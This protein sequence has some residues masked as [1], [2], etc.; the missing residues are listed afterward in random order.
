MP[1]LELPPNPSRTTN[2]TANRSVEPAA[3][4]PG[5]SPGGLPIPIKVR[6][7]RYGELEEHEVIHLLTALDEES[8]RAR[9]RESVYI[10]T[11]FFF[12]LAWFLFYGP[13]VLFH[14]PELVDPIAL[15]KQ[16]DKEQVTFLN[17]PNVPA[18]KPPP[19]P[20]LDRK[21]MQQ[22]QRQ[23]A[24][25]APTP[26]PSAPPPPPQ[27]EARNTAP[28]VPQPQMPL[29]SAPTPKPALA[30]SPLPAAPK[31]N[32]AQNSNGPGDAI[33][34]A[35]RNAM[36]ARAEYGPAPGSS[37]PLQ[38]GTEILSDTMGVDFGPYMRRLH[39]DIQRNWEP[40]IP[41]EVAPPL[42]KRG[43]ARIRF[44][45][46]PDG[47]IGNMFLETPSGDVALDRAAWN[48]ITSEGQFPP[49]PKEFHGPLL[50]LRDTF[51][52]NIPYPQ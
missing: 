40:L 3:P 37:S 45:I 19:H 30:D 28:P 14:Q 1:I 18:P 9:F 47:Q 27:E 7:G 11:L 22:I 24:L 51:L 5:N 12:A 46:L 52:Y 39:N 6:T 32:L 4:A 25:A 31:P 26:Q 16:H 21:T 23:A 17:P 2:E 20:V 10:S 33:Q 41:E 43:I 42:S 29:P 8:A 15:M 48:A 44:T 36:G 50:E 13:R 49:L 35:A 34:R 38:A